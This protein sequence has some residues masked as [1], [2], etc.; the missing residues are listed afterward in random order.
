MGINDQGEI[1]AQGNFPNGDIHA[2]I[3]I[4]CDTNHPGIEGCDYNTVEVETKAPIRA[5]QYAQAP[6]AASAAK[7]SP[8]EMMARFRSLMAGRNRRHGMPQTSRQ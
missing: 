8:A 1:A 6:A 4:P 5:A 2:F 7:L 3:L